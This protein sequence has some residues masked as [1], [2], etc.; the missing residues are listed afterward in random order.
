MQNE[1]NR[2][3]K[4]KGKRDG[5]SL[6][7]AA[8]DATRIND[9]EADPLERTSSELCFAAHVISLP[10]PVLPARACCRSRESILGLT[11]RRI[12]LA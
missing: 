2:K 10:P 5:R 12:I 3:K 6:P 7:S 8:R 9:V 1:I 4:I 11:S